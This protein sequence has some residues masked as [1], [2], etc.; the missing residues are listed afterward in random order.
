MT[1]H[2]A[3]PERSTSAV[4]GRRPPAPPTPPTSAAR[5][6]GG[7][8][9]AAAQRR[10]RVGAI[11]WQ[12]RTLDLAVAVTGLLVLSP[13]LLVL[14]V[15]VRLSSP[16]PVIFRQVR[17]TRGRQPFTLYK[18]R[19]MRVDT[20]G[21]EVTRR[22]DPR[23][24]R[25]GRLLRSTSLDELPQ[26]V[27]ILCGQ[28]TLVGP[29]PET[30]ALAARYPAEVAWVLDETPGLTG[31]TQI[32][33]R[34]DVSVPPSQDGF[35]PSDPGAVERW[36]L[37]QLVPRRVATDLTFLRRPTLRATLRIIALTARYIVTG[38]RP[39]IRPAA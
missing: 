22:A 28:M 25:P 38:R 23:V 2:D 19:T 7:T 29:R 1:I 10:P 26:L 21:P 9:S 27:N 8:G 4:V 11:S 14:A 20:T 37:E 24:T 32:T 17:L 35:D 31:P 5:R 16:G 12:R 39:E 18:F 6:A 30:P 34:D 3:V 36:Y 33:L 13:V 15:A